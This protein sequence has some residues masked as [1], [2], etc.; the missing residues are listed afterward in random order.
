VDVRMP[1]LIAFMMFVISVE[2][3]PRYPFGQEII[4]GHAV[5]RRACS[6]LWGEAGGDSINATTL[7]A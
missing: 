3:G 1:A 4:D 6:P 7:A 2:F 5:R